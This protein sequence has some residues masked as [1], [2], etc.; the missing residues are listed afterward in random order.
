MGRFSH[1]VAI[2]WSG[3]QGA[4]QRGIAVAICSADT[5]AGPALVRPDH[6]W[7]REEV[8]DWML[9]EMPS[10]TLVGMDLGASLPFLDLGVFFPGWDHSPS[11]AKSLWALIDR[12]CE[13]DPN[14]SAASFVDHSDASRHFRRHG[15]REGD[16]FGGGRGRLRITEVAQQAQGLNPYSNLNLVGAAQV[17]KSSLTGMRLLH[18]A[19]SRFP[20]WP[21]DPEPGAGSLILEIYTSLAAL[22]G[23]KR[24]GQTKIY[25]GEELDL[26]LA[27]FGCPP[28]MT[29][30]SSYTDHATDALLTAAWLRFVHDR[31]H[32]WQ[33]VGMTDEVA[34]TEGWT[35]G[36]A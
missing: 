25:C 31:P 30:R 34:R 20:I 27:T 5:H 23:G 7:S 1:F 12:I 29:P 11:D 26:R 19:Q 35:F 22:A 4:R 9:G 10:D 32:L 21:F 3:A 16:L 13:Q 18:R 24:K 6:I 2:D 28:H 15:G 33:P 8:L 17:G 14:L 36:V